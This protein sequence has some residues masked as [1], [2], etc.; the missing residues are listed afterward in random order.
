MSNN[1]FKV[2]LI[3]AGSIAHSHAEA[4]MSLEGV[5]VPIVADINTS[6]AQEFI[7]RHGIE[8]WTEDYKEILGMD[9]IDAVVLCLPNY[10]HAPIA[11]E[12]MRAGKH[13][14][15]EKPM[16]T[17]AK[18]A[19]EMIDVRDETGK[20]LMITM[21]LR[22]SENT[23]AASEFAKD[24]MGDIYY[25]KCGYMRRSGIPGW[26]SWF[27]R[28]EEAGGG[29]CSDIAVHVLDQCLAIMDFPNPVSVTASTYSTFGP[30]GRGK[31]GWGYPELDGFFDVEDLASAF[32]RFDNGATVIM[33]A[34]WAMHL[35]D[36]QWVEVLGTEGGVKIEN[37][38]LN[39]Y[40]EEG[41][42]PFNMKPEVKRENIT[43]NTAEHFIEC[44]KTG[45]KPITSPE[46]GLILIKIF[47]AVYESSAQNGKQ[48]EL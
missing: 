5:E 3:G 8:S 7:T 20:T 39:L 2:A 22:H 19:Q 28:K 43:V 9:D 14:L 41:G 15:V 30:E 34:S 33:E 16:A 36:R 13:V 26:G 42:R 1:V 25:A 46:R 4:Y 31:G 12:A 35:P 38:E 17:N 6:R 23:K 24:N 18:E 45:Q 21:Q 48:I 47:D 29:P 40:K 10:L 37:G 32:I 11:I 27:T 44:C